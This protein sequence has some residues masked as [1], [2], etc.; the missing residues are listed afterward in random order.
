MQEARQHALPKRRAVFATPF[1]M[2]CPVCGGALPMAAPTEEMAD[3]LVECR[4][5]R[6]GA[7]GTDQRDLCG[8]FARVTLT[9]EGFLVEPVGT[10]QARALIRRLSGWAGGWTAEGA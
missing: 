5:P 4:T 1:R 7:Q 2:R 9:A 6:R 10:R 3:V 8:A